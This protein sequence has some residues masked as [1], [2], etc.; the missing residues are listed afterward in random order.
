MAPP[1]LRTKDGFELQIG[2]NHLG[3]FLLTN[4]LLPLIVSDTRESRIVN[5]SSAAHLFGHINFDDLQ[6][7]KSF[8]TWKAYGQ[9]KLANVL[10][11]YELARR[12]PPPTSSAGTTVNALHP[13]VVATELSRYMMPDNP[14]VFQKAA[15]MVAK[16]F[17]L[18][19]E[20][21]AETSIY[22]ASSQEMAGVTGKYLDKCKPV[23]SSKESYDVKVAKK[24]WDLSAELTGLTP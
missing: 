20:Q 6:S 15:M 9:S 7:E 3:H 4:L 18:T 22:A 23:V 19:P 24:L 14:N 1:L 12:L 11:S 21:G 13:G 10:F 2:V 5:V 17:V 8:D 16:N